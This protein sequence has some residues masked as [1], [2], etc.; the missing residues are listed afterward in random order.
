MN[1][2]LKSMA[3]IAGLCVLTAFV[4][5]ILLP[6]FILYLCLMGLAE[7]IGIFMRWMD[8]AEN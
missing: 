8:C 2:I 4:I 1:S 5:F 7:L 6:L 3:I